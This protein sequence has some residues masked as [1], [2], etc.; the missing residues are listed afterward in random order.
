[1]GVAIGCGC[2]I[3]SYYLSLLLYLFFF[4]AAS[5]LFV[6]FLNVFRSF[7]ITIVSIIV[8]ISLQILCTYCSVG[9]L[10]KNQNNFFVI[11]TIVD[12]LVNLKPNF[13]III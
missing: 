13:I 5:L 10:F 2:K 3:S 4:A 9:T 7:I 8:I 11:P 12:L 6:H 1:M